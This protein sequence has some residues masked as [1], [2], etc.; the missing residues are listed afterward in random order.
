MKVVIEGQGAPIAS[1]PARRSL[2]WDILDLPKDLYVQN[3]E[4]GLSK[5]KLFEQNEESLT[6]P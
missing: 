5:L 6:I 3:V 4:F 2:M 1:N